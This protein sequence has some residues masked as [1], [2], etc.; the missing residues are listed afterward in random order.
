MFHAG[1]PTPVP[2][3]N[4]GTGANN[5]ATA[6][7][8]LGANNAGNLTT[9]TLPMAR[10]P[11]KVAYGSGSVSGSSGLTINYASAGFTYVPCVVV[12]SHLGLP[13]PE[14][15]KAVLEQRQR[16]VLLCQEQGDG[17]GQYRHSPGDPR[18]RTVQGGSCWVLCGQRICPINLACCR[19]TVMCRPNRSTG[20][21]SPIWSAGRLQQASGSAS[22]GGS[23]GPC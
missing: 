3:A 13:V 1:M 12:T 8:N 9:G 5:A 17:L 11:F 18:A 7:S 6:R 4:G 16:H 21:G 15:L 19:S 2:I 14:R 22:H 10:L 20:S 23:D